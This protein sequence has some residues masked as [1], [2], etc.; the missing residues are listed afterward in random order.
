MSL[1]QKQMAPLEV[2]FHHLRPI[3]RDDIV[4]PAGVLERIERH[5]RALRR[6]TGAAGRRRPLFDPVTE[7]GDLTKALLGAS[8]PSSR[9]PSC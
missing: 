4:L 2:A 9:R 7:G 8:S 3:Q 1:V 6:A 5:T